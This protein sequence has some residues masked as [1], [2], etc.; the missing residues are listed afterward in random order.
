MNAPNFTTEKRCFSLRSRKRDAK[1][2]RR[3]RLTRG[4]HA[5]EQ[6]MMQTQYHFERILDRCELTDRRLLVARCKCQRYN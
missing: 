3:C 4:E 6:V 2:L 1:V 5:D